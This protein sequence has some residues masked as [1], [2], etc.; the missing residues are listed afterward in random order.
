MPAIT[1]RNDL[2][3]VR[4]GRSPLTNVRGGRVMTGE[5]AALI[6]QIAELREC[7]V[8]HLVIEFL[9]VDGDD[10]TDAMTVFAERVRPAL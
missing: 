4:P 10:L 1:L 8:E 5:P 9:A 6:D 3:L 2:S 7:G